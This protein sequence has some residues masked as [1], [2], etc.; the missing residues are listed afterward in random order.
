MFTF[1]AFFCCSSSLLAQKSKSI[2]N[3]KTYK[4]LS[5]NR[6]TLPNQWKLT[7]AGT[8]LQ[9]G[10]LPLNVLLSPSKKLMAV[11]NNGVGKH[12][13]QLFST[14]GTVKEVSQVDIAKAWYGLAFSSDEKRLYASGGNDNTVVIFK[15]DNQKLTRDTAIILGK[16][17]PKGKI[18]PA[19]IALDDATNRLFTVT[20]ED[21]ALYVCNTQSLKI[22]KKIP[23]STEP[24]SVV[25]SKSLNEIYVSLWGAKSIAVFDLKTLD[26]KT[27]I[28]VGDHPNEIILNKKQDALFVANSLDNSVSIID[29]KTKK[30]LETLNAALYPN[31]PNGSTTNGLALSEDEKTLYIANADNNCLAVFNVEKMGNSYSKG[32]IPTGWYPTSVK[33]LGKKIFVTNGKGMSSAANPNGPSPFKKKEDNR[34]G[35]YIGQLFLGTLSVIDVPKDKQLAIY[36]KLTYENTPYTK[37]KE[38]LT[39]GEKGNPIP[40]RTGDVSPIKYVFYIIKENRTYDQVLA[41]VPGGNGDTSLL[42]FPESVTPNQHKIV[43]DFVLF[44]NFYVDAE[45]SADGHNW[46]T[47][48]YANDFVEKTWVASYGGKGGNYDFEGTRKVAFPKSGFIWDNCKRN[49]ITYR[50]YGEFADENKANYATLDGHYCTYYHDF[51]MNFQDSR[52]EKDWERD[53]DSLLNINQVPRFNTVRLGNDHTSG[54][55]KGAYSPKASVADNDLA[56]GRFVE[57]LSQTSIWK[58]SAVFIIEDD[59]QNGADHVDAHRSTAYIISPYIKRKN[60]DHT[61]YSTSSMVRTM[62]LILGMPPMSQYDAAATPMYRAFTSQPDFTPFKSVEPLININERNVADNELSR[63]SQYFNLAELDAVPEREF[64]DVL[65]KSIKGLNSEMPAPVRAAFVKKSVKK[66][67]DDD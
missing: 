34:G 49:G 11:T 41:D 47:A 25:I 22:E 5:S 50:T 18:C 55:S 2:Q 17:W 35:Q 24:F 21:S 52:R 63:R 39:E 31:A 61:M 44:D 7:P 45:V 32:F 33:V 59:A 10:D 23:L 60:I 46:S 51:D 58:E 38:T 53:F 9:L 30:V 54:M 66:D 3:D 43:K 56:V 36:S 16:A 48:A 62:E 8:S 65:W 13:I 67:K 15:V 27:E 14:E 40:M 20:K 42:L 28:A 26:K 6:V 4:T 37:E 1:L 29:L 64:N 57:H 19:G 12:F